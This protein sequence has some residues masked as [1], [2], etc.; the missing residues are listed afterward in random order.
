MVFFKDKTNNPFIITQ[1]LEFL[2]AKAVERRFK[3]NISI[4]ENDL[5]VNPDYITT[6]RNMDVEVF[7]ST[8]WMNGVLVQMDDD[9]ALNV[10]SLSFVSSIEYVAPNAPLR[11]I[12]SSKNSNEE[13]PLTFNLASGQQE[14]LGID[15]MH[16]FGFRGESLLIGIFDDGFQ[17]Y[18]T[19][20]AFASLRNQNR[21]L[22]EFDFVNNVESAENRFNHGTRVFSII[23]ANTD[24]YQG[25][26]P[27]AT[28]ILSVTEAEREYRIEEYNW[29]F[30]AEKADSA[31]VDIIN[32]SLGYFQGFSD[33]S[34]NYRPEDLNGNTAVITRAANIAASKGI[35]LINSAG[36][37][38]SVV[39]APADSPYVLA[40]GAIDASWMITNFSSRG[41]FT[42]NAFKPDLVA[43]GGSTLLLTA[44]GNL[45][46]QSGTSFS[47]PLVTSLAAGVW[48]AYPKKTASEIRQMI[49]LSGDR[50][51][52]PD[53]VYGYGIPNFERIVEL[54][55][56]TASLLNYEIF[57]NPTTEDIQLRFSE[58]YYGEKV[59][60][61]IIQ[62]S[63]NLYKEVEFIPFEVLNPLRITLEEKGM[64]ILRVVSSSGSIS[65]KIIKY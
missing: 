23:A 48:Q 10:Q 13:S 41:T 54:S 45:A 4:Q 28:F 26:A 57:P 38:G 44:Q 18:S 20:E 17:N 55:R 24:D 16:Q 21:I 8:K 1:P 53:Q 14:E 51:G 65:K 40:I 5:P 11:P 7:F 2:S 12:D 29:L 35:L 19:L 27:E 37:S 49:R 64:Y 36:N 33:V 60:V 30:A 22:Y 3:Q 42:A 43:R 25:G 9:Q 50:V 32:T 62:S 31:G 46:A 58:K 6:L 34:M 63:G 61:Q 39:V 59:L 47:A 52:N 15:V 56:N